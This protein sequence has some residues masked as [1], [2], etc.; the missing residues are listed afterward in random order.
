MVVELARAVLKPPESSGV[1]K[2]LLYW[3][4]GWE[5]SGVDIWRRV[6]VSA[7]SAKIVVVIPT[8]TVAARVAFT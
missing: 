3:S 1:T 6:M 4:G 5:G 2:Q 8:I 7:V